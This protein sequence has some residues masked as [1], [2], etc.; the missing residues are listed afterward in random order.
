[1]FS[2]LY[3]RADILIRRLSLSKHDFNMGE[4]FVDSVF[5]FFS[6]AIQKRIRSFEQRQGAKKFQALVTKQA[7]DSRLSDWGTVYHVEIEYASE[8]KC[9]I[10][11]N[12]IPLTNLVTEAFD[13]DF[14]ILNSVFKKL[15][16]S[17][18]MQKIIKE[19]FALAVRNQ[20]T[21]TFYETEKGLLDWVQ[22]HEHVSVDSDDDNEVEVGLSSRHD[23]HHQLKS[24][25]FEPSNF[26][27]SIHCVWKLSIQIYWPGD[28]GYDS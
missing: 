3:Q 1:M 6:D 15:L 22:D 17:S 12:N 2:S 27:F 9:V 19:V 18:S 13:P 23:Y 7:E 11:F 8:A 25:T 28:R 26:S 14:G 20:E 16:N 5:A 24:V 21:P 10:R 4:A